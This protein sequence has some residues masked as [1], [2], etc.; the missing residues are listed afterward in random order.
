M[1]QEE[2]HQKVDG[3]IESGPQKPVI[4]RVISPQGYKPTIHR[5]F[6]GHS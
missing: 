6:I 4:S 3:G 2:K 1:F 5:P